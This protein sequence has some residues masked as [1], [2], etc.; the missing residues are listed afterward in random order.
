VEKVDTPCSCGGE[1]VL[2]YAVTPRPIVRCTVCKRET[3]KEFGKA[4]AQAVK[5]WEDMN[6]A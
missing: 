6:H 5:E 4:P 2:L 1:A 3:T